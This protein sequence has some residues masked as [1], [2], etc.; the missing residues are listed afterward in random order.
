MVGT[1][2]DLIDAELRAEEIRTRPKDMFEFEKGPSTKPKPKPE[3]DPTKKRR[4]PRRPYREF[5]GPGWQM[6]LRLP[7][8]LVDQIKEIIKVIDQEEEYGLIKQRPRRKMERKHMS[9][10]TFIRRVLVQWIS[11]RRIA[12]KTD[13]GNTNI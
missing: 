1:I 13:Q 8:E 3:P 6:C 12:R 4:S 11:R 10:N 5:P 2:K 7:Q 9:I